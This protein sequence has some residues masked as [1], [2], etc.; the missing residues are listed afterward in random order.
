MIWIVCLEGVPNFGANAPVISQLSS[1]IHCH[2]LGGPTA[3]A[4]PLAC[5]TMRGRRSGVWEASVV[6]SFCHHQAASVCMLHLD[7]EPWSYLNLFHSAWPGSFREL[8]VRFACV[9][10]CENDVTWPSHHWV[11]HK[12]GC[13][14]SHRSCPC[15]MGRACAPNAR[16]ASDVSSVKRL[17]WSSMCI[18][19]TMWI[20]IFK[21]QY[22]SIR[23]MQRA[24]SLHLNLSCQTSSKKWFCLNI[25][26]KRQ[27]SPFWDYP[28][29]SY[30]WYVCSCLPRISHRIHRIS[31]SI[32]MKWY[33]TSPL[34]TIMWLAAP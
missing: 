13:Q 14:S 32:L 29:L 23:D 26:G 33:K 16:P 19:M 2:P 30:C 1:V 20:K 8:F 31:H 24:S 17:L 11:L 9:K 3:V 22:A 18:V 5:R 25:V 28:I 34:N 12:W 10:P 27:N 21:H 4:K 6:K 15:S 7:V